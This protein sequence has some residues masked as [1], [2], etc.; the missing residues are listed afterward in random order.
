M[1]QMTELER[2]LVDL[3]IDECN[4]FEEPQDLTPDSPIV[5]PN[6]PFELDSLDAVE[7]VVGVQ[8]KYGVRIGNQD[9]SRKVF[10]SIRTLANYIQEHMDA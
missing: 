6:S 4:V 8:R 5:G 10:E 1:E 2:D 7:I 9:T 3:I